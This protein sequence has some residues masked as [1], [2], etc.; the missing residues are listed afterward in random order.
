MPANTRRTPRVILQ[1][2]LHVVDSHP[3]LPGSDQLV[4]LRDPRERVLPAFFEILLARIPR[5][6]E[7]IGMRDEPRAVVVNY[8]R[9]FCGRLHIENFAV[10]VAQ[11]IV[12]V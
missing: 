1:K 9:T 4:N 8:L 12:P 2:T 11:H 5:A 3:T 7:V 6:Q 10:S